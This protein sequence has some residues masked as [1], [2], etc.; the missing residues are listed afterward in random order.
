MSPVR[1]S[2]S[3][4]QLY[5]ECF[6]SSLKARGCPEPLESY[7]TIDT[8]VTISSPPLGLQLAADMASLQSRI[9]WGRSQLKEL[10]EKLKQLEPRAP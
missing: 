1:F 6:R 10:Q 9:N 7:G 2:K 3:Q 4:C 8:T 5:L